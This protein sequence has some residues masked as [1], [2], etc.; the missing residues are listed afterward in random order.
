MARAMW[1]GSLDL[2]GLSVPIKL[3]SA[4]Q[5]RS[6]HFRLVDA[7]SGEPVEQRMVHR[8]TGE[9]VESGHVHK[10]FPLEDGSF[11]LLEPEELAELEPKAS[12][13]IEISRFVPRGAVPRPFYMRPYYLGPDG[14]NEAYFALARALEAEKRDGIAH[15]VM[16]KKTYH[17]LLRAADGYLALITLRDPAEVI[18]A[19]QLPR[20]EGKAHGKRELDMAEQ[21]IEAY[22]GE[23]ELATLRDEYRDRV[24]ELVEAKAE[25]KR[26]RVK[27]ARA[28]AEAP[29]LA[30]ALARS[31]KSVKSVRRVA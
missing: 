3:Y 12:R 19:A 22:S 8:E 27:K 20:P 31:L 5:D 6:V 14:A 13:D 4:V 18:S 26:P 17:G 15:W 25:G 24:M 28:K 2:G 1:K 21:L 23:L 30:D 9:P 7:A 16:R 11:V 10:G 29:D